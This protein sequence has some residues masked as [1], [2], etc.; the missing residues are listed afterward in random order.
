MINNTAKLGTTFHML[1]IAGLVL[2]KPPPTTTGYL[3]VL[4]SNHEHITEPSNLNNRTSQS[5]SQN[6]KSDRECK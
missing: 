3:L 6:H 5:A 4:D 2:A 1:P